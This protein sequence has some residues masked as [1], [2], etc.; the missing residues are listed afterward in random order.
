MSETPNVRIPTQER[1]VRTRAALVDAAQKEFS[2]HGYAATTARSIAKAAGVST[3]S[4]YQ[5]F[6]DKDAVLRELG[7][8]RFEA[9]ARRIFGF[10]TV[11]GDRPEDTVVAAEVVHDRLRS[12]VDAVAD[13]HREDPGLHEVLTERRHHDEELDRL[14]SA[15]EA[16]IVTQVA[17]LLRWWGHEGDAEA[18]AFVIFGMVEGTVHAHVLGHAMV[19]DERCFAALVDAVARVAMVDLGGRRSESW[20]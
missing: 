2:Q 18:T 4:F 19:D 14:T 10:L 16:L 17:Q 6:V 7:R 3:G 1:A 9:I 5:Y 15:G 8:A 11:E 13:Y 12:V 20:A